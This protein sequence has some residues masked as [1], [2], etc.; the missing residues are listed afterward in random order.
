VD[1]EKNNLSKLESDVGKARKQVQF[2]KKI[3]E[4]EAKMY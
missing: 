1:D 3:I 4:N 2:K